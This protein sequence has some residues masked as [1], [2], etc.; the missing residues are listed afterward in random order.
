MKKEFKGLLKNYTTG[1]TEWRYYTN[2]NK[3]VQLTSGK[4]AFFC[5]VVEDLQWTGLKDMYN[6]KIY[7]GDVISFQ[8]DGVEKYRKKVVFEAKTTEA[9][10]TCG[11]IGWHKDEIEVIGNIYENPKLLQP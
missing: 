10:F 8:E 1:I 7:E 2:D 5:W 11:A 9:I 4:P 3:P 6:N